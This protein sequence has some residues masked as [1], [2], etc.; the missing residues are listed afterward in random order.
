MFH[1]LTFNEKK[2]W[3]KKVETQIKG[4][5]QYG[6]FRCGNHSDSVTSSYCQNTHYFNHIC[7]PNKTVTTYAVTKHTFMKNQRKTES[8]IGAFTT[9]DRKWYKKPNTK[10]KV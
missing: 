2:K 5:S 9:D 3:K 6:A 4:K 8:Q 1:N 10:S 7:I